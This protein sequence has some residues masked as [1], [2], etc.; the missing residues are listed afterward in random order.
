MKTLSKRW[1]LGATVLVIAAAAAVMGSGAL[2][3]SKDAPAAAK[4]L[5]QLSGL[6]PRDHLTVESAIQVEKI[7]G[8]GGELRAILRRC[9]VTRGIL[10]KNKVTG[11]N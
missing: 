11:N 6:L 2:A 10:I 1:L 8:Y 3:G 7:I 9:C 5:G 4:G